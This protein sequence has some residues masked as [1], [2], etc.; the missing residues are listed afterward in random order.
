M[1]MFKSITRA[2][3]GAVLGVAALTSCAIPTQTTPGPVDTRPRYTIGDIPGVDDAAVFAPWNQMA[4]YTIIANSPTPNLAIHP[5]TP[6]YNPQ[7]ERVP[8][9]TVV[10]HPAVFY[11]PTMPE[12]TLIAVWQ[13]ELGHIILE[14]P[15]VADTDCAHPMRGVLSYCEFYGQPTGWF[16]P[17]DKALLDAAIASP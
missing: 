6:L 14:W 13:H 5:I 3:V 9:G 1:T 11:D 10:G 7:G 15:P 2:I 12:S 16:G 8:A 17:G 4:G